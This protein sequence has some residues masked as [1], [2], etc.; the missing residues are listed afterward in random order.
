MA[1][2]GSVSL[3][4]SYRLDVGMVVLDLHVYAFVFIHEKRAL[5]RESDMM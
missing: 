3:A 5:E 4:G 1:G 2:A